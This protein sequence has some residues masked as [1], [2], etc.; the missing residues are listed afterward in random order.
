MAVTFQEATRIKHT[1]G[2]LLCDKDETHH[3]QKCRDPGVY[4]CAWCG[5]LKVCYEEVLVNKLST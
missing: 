1:D 2:K 4:N 3:L 5:E